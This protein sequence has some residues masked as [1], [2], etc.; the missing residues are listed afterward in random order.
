MNFNTQLFIENTKRIHLATTEQSLAFGTISGSEVRH[1]LSEIIEMDKELMSYKGPQLSNLVSH[2]QAFNKALDEICTNIVGNTMFKLLLVKVGRTRRIHLVNYDGS[3]S[4]FSSEDFA[5]KVNLSLYDSDGIGIPSRQYYYINQDGT[6]GNKLK[7]L[8][9]SI[10]HEFCHALHEVSNTKIKNCTVCAKGSNMKIVWDHD[11]E[12]R[13]ITC[14]NYDPICDHI[15]GFN[16]SIIKGLTFLPRYQRLAIV[17]RKRVA[18]LYFRV[19][20]IYGQLE[21]VSDNIK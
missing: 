16:Q 1:R 3:G 11:E 10:F 21:G 13:N 15:F 17:Q 2:K 14:F 8:T 18:K 12:L 4:R 20:E 5:V 9:G 6:I 7:S 19:P